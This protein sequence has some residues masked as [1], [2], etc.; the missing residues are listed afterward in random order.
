MMIETTLLNT[1]KLRNDVDITQ[2]KQ[3]LYATNM[4]EA[5]ILKDS[6]RVIIRQVHVLCSVRYK[7][8]FVTA[9]VYIFLK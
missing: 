6:L 3:I 4:K 9:K 8:R 2:I 7:G 1:L 5:F